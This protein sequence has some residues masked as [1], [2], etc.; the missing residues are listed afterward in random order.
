MCNKREQLHLIHSRKKNSPKKLAE[1][2]L[3]QT[4]P[5]KSKVFSPWRK[6]TVPQQQQK[7]QTTNE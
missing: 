1:K 5:I 7:Q 6:K 2:V 3:F 4:F